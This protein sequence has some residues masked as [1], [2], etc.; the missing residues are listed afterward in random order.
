MAMKLYTERYIQ[1]IANAIRAKNGKT[2][3]Y[4]VREMAPAVI[5]LMSYVKHLA[6]MSSWFARSIVTGTKA[7]DFSIYDLEAG[8]AVFDANG[9]Y[10]LPALLNK[11]PRLYLKIH[12]TDGEWQIYPV[13]Y[14]DA[15]GM[16]PNRSNIGVY[17][18]VY[19]NNVAYTP[20]E[21]TTWS[22][23]EFGN[24]TNLSTEFEN[25]IF[26]KAPTYIW[27]VLTAGSH[28]A[29][30]AKL[31]DTNSGT[32]DFSEF[33]QEFKITDLVAVP[34]RLNGHV[35]NAIVYR[36]NLIVNYPT[37]TNGTYFGVFFHSGNEKVYY[38]TSEGKLK[39][40]RTMK[41]YIAPASFGSVG[42]AGICTYSND[43]RVAMYFGKMD[44]S[45][46]DSTTTFD[47]TINQAGVA[48]TIPFR[49][50]DILDQN[51]NILAPKNC[52]LS[53]FGIEEETT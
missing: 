24:H 21:N 49:T 22:A 15:Y 51:G 29:A 9:H 2:R 41:S 3:K 27:N 52:D 37:T 42:I 34:E 39:S 36:N 44:V 32:I 33:S 35:V 4:K 14:T 19:G 1:A 40:A 25:S 53:D 8:Y 31:D 45:E 11:N 43:N 46:S 10:V 13:L 50:Y 5:D 47:L 7:P 26:S 6:Q 48:D 38:D 18:M 30:L 28:P 17:P 23:G 12:A 20:G 16:F